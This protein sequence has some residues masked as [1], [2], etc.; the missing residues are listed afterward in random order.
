MQVMMVVVCNGIEEL[1]AWDIQILDT[2][3][4]ASLNAMVQLDERTP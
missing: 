3:A 4:R 2:V 1:E